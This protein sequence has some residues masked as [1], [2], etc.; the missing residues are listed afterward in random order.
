[1][2]IKIWT[3]LDKGIHKSE[4]EARAVPTI[5]DA[6]KANLD[7][8][9]AFALRASWENSRLYGSVGSGNTYVGLFDDRGVKLWQTDTNNN[10]KGK[11]PMI[12][13]QG[14]LTVDQIADLREPVFDG[15][16]WAELDY[17]TIESLADYVDWE[18]DD[19][20]WE[21]LLGKHK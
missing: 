6:T 4:R 20:K 19:A 3:E 8:A 7:F 18:S 16:N 12:T 10:V 1:M 9:K 13:K 21:F 11:L 2:K 14:S 5:L 15:D 17:E